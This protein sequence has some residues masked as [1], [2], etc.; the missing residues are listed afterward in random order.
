MVRMVI[1]LDEKDK[2]WLVAYARKHKMSI[3]EVVRLA[4]KQ[5]KD[6]N[7]KYDCLD[8]L[9]KTH[10]LG[11]DKGIDGLILLTRETKDLNSKV[12]KFVKLP[13]RRKT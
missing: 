1:S 6:K 11:K 9:A 2:K 12:L 13:A 4:I 8:V 3:A 7:E 5:L 10:G